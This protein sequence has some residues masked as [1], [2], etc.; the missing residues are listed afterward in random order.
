[1]NKTAIKNF[2]VWARQKLIADIKYKTKMLG[3]DENGIAEPEPHSDA[4]TLIL[5]IAGNIKQFHQKGITGRRN[6]LASALLDREQ[7]TKS[8]KEAFENAVEEAAYTW[9]NRLIALRFMEV[10][11]YLPSRVRV[12]SSLNPDKTEPDIVTDPFDANFEYTALEREK[13][14]EYKDKN[15]NDELFRMLFIKQCNELYKVLPGLFEKTDDYNELLLTVSFTDTDGVVWHLIHDIPESDFDVKK[16]G[17]VEIIGWFYQYYNIEPKDRVF[18]NLKKNIKISTD[19]IPAATQLFTPHWIVSYM[20]ENSLGRL[21]YENKSHWLADAPDINRLEQLKSNWKYYLDEAEQE[22]EVRKKLDEIRGKGPICLDDIKLLDPCMG[23]GHIL[24]Y[25]FDVLMQIYLSCGYTERDAARLI[26]KNNLYGLEIDKRA[27]Q[28]AYFAVMMKARQY[29][30]GFLNRKIKP[31]VY[32]I[33][34]SNKV[35]A[36]M[37]NNVTGNNSKIKTDLESVMADMYDAEQYGSIISVSPIDFNAIYNRIDEIKEEFKNSEYFENIDENDIDDY[38]LP[39]LRVAEIL[40]Q[41]Y[42]VVCTNPPYM[43]ASGMNPKLSKYVKNNFPNTKSDLFAVFIEKYNKMIKTN[44][45]NCMVTMQ[46]WM[47]LS[48]FEKMRKNILE[49]MTITNLMHMENMVM[50]IAF[51]TAV[52]VFKN[53]FIPNYKGTYNQIKL[54]DI[55]TG[56][57]KTFPVKENRFAQVSASNFSKI[58]GS[59]IAYW[60]SENFIQAFENGITI[61]DLSDFTGSQNITANN[62]KYLRYF[63]E[64]YYNKI[65]KY[66]KWA[67]YAKGG[68]YRKWYGNIDL[69]VDISTEAMNYYKNNSSSNLLSEKYWFTEG[70]T[71]SAI[72][73]KGTG[74]RYYPA[75]GGF[76]KGG[77]AICYVKHFEYVIGFLN[78]TIAHYFFQLLNP[79]INLQV[80]DIKALPIIKDFSKE[81]KISDIVKQ[82]VLLSKTDWDSYET[83]W[84]FKCLPL[85]NLSRGLWD[86]TRVNAAIESYYGCYPKADSPLELCYL[87][88]KGECNER[89]GRLKAN[90][91]ELNRIFID[92]YGLRDELTP[93]VADRDVTV[94]YVVD[95]KD[96]IPESLKGS[97]YVR[98][99]RDEIVSLI[100]YAVGCMFGRYSLD[101]EGLVYAGGDFSDQ[102]SVTGGQYAPDEDNCIPITDE[103]YFEDDIVGRF[104]EFIETVYGKDTL[105]ENLKFIASALGGKG[106]SSR[107][108]IRSYFLKDFIKDH[109]KTYKKRPIYWMF[110]SGRQNGFKA[111]VYMHRWNAD[112]IGNVRVEYLHRVQNIYEREISRM[113]EITDSGAD[114]REIGRASKRREKLLKQLKET[115][116]YD[117]KIAHLALSRIDIDLDDGVKVN[118]EK[119]QTGKDGNKMQILTKI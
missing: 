18:A 75:I 91:K 69:V 81:N 40:A 32:A 102:W 10:N 88:W 4:D 25:A 23:S 24:V 42:D 29:D 118:Y 20:V 72:T 119:V 27:T 93:E 26:V 74:F 103:Q 33:E 106:N 99:K 38:I 76:D 3:I 82:N 117:E 107:E 21:Y 11:N 22:P 56:I 62:D 41:K 84:D 59:P 96:D 12:L 79:T 92:I 71:Y 112:T 66:L 6:S 31:N 53:F 113:Q 13:I 90:E 73:S 57:P 7:K 16:E 85:V 28:L 65:G 105:E 61:D 1:M 55:E 52:T 80:K 86:A 8:Y 14:F 70:I 98:T 34:E 37:I 109:I 58:P 95:S 108:V 116:D 77:A 101:R 115:R 35:S 48:S 5:N 87:L 47:F 68:E 51:G 39:V 78:T 89:F 67:Y 36:A 54:C 104:V 83:S 17:Q 19:N 100:S 30:R 60:V 50:G 64:I 111:L 94:H 45:Y 2:A 114:S 15:Q 63:W 46:S 43:G 9:F 110:D 44:G 97:N 49:S